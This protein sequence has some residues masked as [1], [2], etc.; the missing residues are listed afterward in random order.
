M[1][2]KKDMD[3]KKGMDSKSYIPLYKQLK[4]KIIEDIENQIYKPDDMIPSQM[5]FVKK[6]GVS[7]VTVRQAINELIQSG[8]LYTQKGKGTFVQKFPIH[9]RGF[10]RL[11]GFSENVEKTGH[12][13]FTK[14][15]GINFIQADK[16]LSEYLKVEIGH[17]VVYVKRVRTARGVPLTLENSYL[18][19]ERVNRIDFFKQFG[20]NRSLYQL[21]R[22][23]AGVRFDYA[24]ENINAVLASPEVA[25]DLGVDVNDPILFIRRVTYESGDIPVEYCE[26]YMRSDVHGIVIRFSNQGE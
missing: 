14:V 24:Q 23:E 5:E 17:P 11:H 1:D 2:G 20:D 7:R 16:K 3:G 26:N 9:Y 6:Y 19:Q 21:L 12:S 22:D 10:N 15:L 13:P 18:N 8:V 25:R 4:N